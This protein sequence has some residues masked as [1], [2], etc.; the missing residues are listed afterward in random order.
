REISDLAAE[1]LEGRVRRVAPGPPPGTEMQDLAWRNVRCLMRIK[2]LVA[3]LGDEPLRE[4]VDAF[5]GTLGD[6]FVSTSV[7]EG[8]AERLREAYNSVTAR[9]V[10]L[11]NESG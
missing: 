2:A 8:D 4:A 5:S 9:V 7:E 11:L 3:R 1:L 10:T 6:F